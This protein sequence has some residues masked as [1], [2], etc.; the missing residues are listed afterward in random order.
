MAGICSRSETVDIPEMALAGL[1]GD[2]ELDRDATR[3][4]M[5]AAVSVSM[6]CERE[7]RSSASCT[8]IASL[9]VRAWDIDPYTNAWWAPTG[10]DESVWFDPE[11]RAQQEELDRRFAASRR[12]SFVVARSFALDRSR[13][14]GSR[15]GYYCWTRKGD[16]EANARTN[17]ELERCQAARNDSRTATRA[18]WRANPAYLT[19]RLVRRSDAVGAAAA[20]WT[21]VARRRWL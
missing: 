18:R 19:R 20:R 21:G 2:G 1:D 11:L 14:R 15:R 7:G 5:M 8:R 3:R 9:D 17:M 4:A 10:P 16:G 12:T 13:E 6:S